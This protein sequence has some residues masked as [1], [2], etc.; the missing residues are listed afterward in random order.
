[1]SFKDNLLKNADDIQLTKIFFPGKVLDNNDPKRLGRLRVKPEQSPNLQKQLDGT[2]FDE[3][4]DKWKNNDPYLFL[5][6]LPYYVYQTPLK[7]EYVH[8]LYYDKNYKDGNRFYIQGNL[9][10]PR[11]ISKEEYNSSQQQLSSGNQ[12]KESDDITNYVGSTGIFPEPGDNSI[13]GRGST[14]LVLK[15]EEVLIR[16][17]KT[18]TSKLEI[19]RPPIPNQFRAFLQLSNFTKTLSE[20]EKETTT[21]FSKVIKT[22]N[23]ILIWNVDNLENNSNQFNGSI[24]V[25]NVIPNSPLINTD[26]FKLGTIS[27][28]SIGTNYQG[29]LEEFDF[30]NYSINE[31]Q[32]L[33]NKI[34]QSL[35]TG[36]IDTLSGYTINSSVNFKPENVFPFVVTP[37]KISYDKGGSFTGNTENPISR[38]IRKNYKELF[39]GIKVNYDENVRG[40]FLVSSNNSG[41]AVI[42]PTYELKKTESSSLI[43][44]NKPSTYGIMGA[45]KLY[46][47]THK[48]TGAPKQEI[49]L[50]DTIYGIKPEKFIGE[51]GIESKTYPMVRGD[52]LIKLLRKL[53]SFVKGH[54]H[55]ISTKPPVSIAA[56]NGQSVDEIEELLANAEITILNQNIRIN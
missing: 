44:S 22:V 4:K 20:S 34:I 30:S 11:Y 49:D 16:A 43:F 54:V 5:P 23:K 17:G 33:I 52:E 36:K 51:G 10:D 9:S 26:N 31:I 1:M 8:I 40:F 3:T 41:N 42:G 56:G 21:S 6:L 27:K 18:E 38:S 48:T 28:L 25:Y 29:P 15:P 55:Q 47:L 2:S 13:L 12:Y 37:S 50:L 53:V 24:G 7:D 39:D 14:D 45:E 32:I 46:F 19:G 35:F